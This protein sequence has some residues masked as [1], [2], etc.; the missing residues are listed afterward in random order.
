MKSS[1]LTA[2]P[3]PSFQPRLIAS[4]K[5]NDDRMK[6][7]YYNNDGTSVR[8]AGIAQRN[9][10]WLEAK[11]DRARKA[12]EVRMGNKEQGSTR[13]KRHSRDTKTKIFD[14]SLVDMAGTEGTGGRGAN[15]PTKCEVK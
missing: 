1:T 8:G 11:K 5:H 10:A 13:I 3:K 4:E 7:S 14:A 15:I 9:E 6:H 12:R 2:I